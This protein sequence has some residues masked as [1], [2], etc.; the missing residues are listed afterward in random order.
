MYED[1]DRYYW[2]KFCNVG[3]DADDDGADLRIGRHCVELLPEQGER[4]FTCRIGTGQI[5]VYQQAI[6]VQQGNLTD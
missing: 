2:C 1:G 6:H 5:G 4:V 3:F